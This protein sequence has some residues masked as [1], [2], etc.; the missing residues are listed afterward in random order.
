M[1][2]LVL[3][4]S[5]M[6]GNTT[7][8]VLGEKAGWEVFGTVR[9]DSVGRFFP[10]PIAER[11]LSDVDVIKHDSLIEVMGRIRPNVVVNCVGL[12]KHK[13][14]GNVPLTAIQLNSLFPHRLAGLCSVAG[15]RLIHVSTDCVFSGEKGNYTEDD[16]PDA[17]DI[18]GKSKSLGEVDYPNTI[19][20]R[21]STIGRELQTAHGLLDWFLSQQ[22]QCKGFKRAVFSGLPTV[23][24]AQLIRDVVIPRPDLSGLYH[25]AARPISKYDLLKLVAD[26]YAKS[27][28][29]VP[30]DRLV[31]DRS[32]NADRFRVA[33]GYVAPEW[34]ELIKTMHSYQ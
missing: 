34:P 21:T 4:A 13:A 16:L 27:I 3:G 17:T 20:L 7:V 28:E 33:T 18:Y 25:V 26:V 8:R 23:V 2:V 22:E 30:D 19:T 31:I 1:K 15:A 14:G 9:A 24:F 12:T 6:I 11:L 5:G 29:I 32:L 10:P